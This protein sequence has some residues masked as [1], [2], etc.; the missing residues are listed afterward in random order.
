VGPVGHSV[1]L[2]GGVDITFSR[3]QCIC[4][5][6]WTIGEMLLYADHVRYVWSRD[7]HRPSVECV[8][9]VDQVSPTECIAI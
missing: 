6:L 8:W 1:G 7:I 4:P 5:T 9:R 3:K 2:R